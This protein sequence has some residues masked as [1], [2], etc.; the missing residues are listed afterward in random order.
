MKLGAKIA[1]G[2]TAGIV[3]V[4]AIAVGTVYGLWHKEINS[5][6]SI[7]QIIPAH[8]ENNAGKVYE[9]TMDGGFYFDDFLEQGGVTNDGDLIQ[10]IVDHITK[11]VI[12]VDMGMDNPE[13]G[14]SSFTV[15]D[16]DG[17][18]LFGR[19]YDFSSTNSLIL[20]TNPGKGRHAT[21]SSVDL[22]FLSLDD[23][24]NDFMDHATAIA[25]AYA[26]LDG[27]NDAGVAC[28]IYMSYQGPDGG[29]V[30]T[31]QNTEKPDLTSTTM[32][33]L[34]LDYAD[35][36]DEAIEL[37][38]QYDFHDSA[39][40][41]FHYMVADA[42]GKSAILEW[43]NGTDL[44]DLD[45]SKRELK[46][47]YNDDDASVGADEARDEFQ[48]ITNFIVTPDYY[49]TEGQKKGLDRYNY[50]KDTINPDGTNAEGQFTKQGALDLLQDLGRRN[51]DKDKPSDSNNITVWSALYD[52]NNKTATW[53]SNEEFDQQGSVFSFSLA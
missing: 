19:N 52:L 32:L 27:M 4:A 9:M 26:P 31:D 5:M 2:V 34:I 33:R 20:H 12:N 29:T 40:S 13:V 8:P 53:V 35:D 10:F 1:I 39:N 49:E 16:E 24:I 6:L 44:T 45:G 11:G 22:Q 46:V 14:C 30:A 21:I 47:Y 41:S 7:K 38:K 42:S 23:G 18:R 17:N 36:V 3:G 15:K 48:Y 43:V 28:G 51:W 50:I 25:A 37:V